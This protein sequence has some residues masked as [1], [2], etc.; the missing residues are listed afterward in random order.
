[1]PNTPDKT[2]LKELLKEGCIEL[3]IDLTD[4]M[5]EKFMRYLNEL[6]TWNK[7]I[8][9]TSV[10]NEKDIVIRHFLDSL[11]ILPIIIK[12]DSVKPVK[13]LDIGS[14]AGF[15]GIPLKIA[16]PRLDVTLVESR[17]KKVYFMRHIIRSLGLGMA[18]KA[19][20]ERAEG[21]EF[22]S[23]HTGSFDIVTSRAFSSLEDF[24][25]VAMP[26]CAPLGRIIAIKGPAVDNEL[27]RVQGLSVLE[28]IK[29]KVPFEDRT[30]SLV[31]FTKE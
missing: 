30:N 29:V 9:L 25:N 17:K 22:I 14:G 19:L 12:A 16:C 10:I 1:M 23:A 4:E 28:I 20:D 24:L 15:P 31:V 18:I 2:M 7:T 26:L 13:L 8:N 5:A 3:G 21:N 11:T 6:K 27:I